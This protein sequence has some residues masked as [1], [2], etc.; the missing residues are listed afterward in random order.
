MPRTIHN[1]R[2]QRQHGR[3]APLAGIARLY[4]EVNLLFGDM[5]RSRLLEGGGDMAL[6]LF[7]RGIGRGRG[8][9]RARGHAFPESS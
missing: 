1:L 9:P 6:F 7:S 2:E 4:A 3:G 5:S 8:E